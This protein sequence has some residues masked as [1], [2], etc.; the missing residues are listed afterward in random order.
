MEYTVFLIGVRSRHVKAFMAPFSE[1]Y[2][3]KPY[4]YKK[5]EEILAMDRQDP[6]MSD[7]E[8]I[9]SLSVY[10]LMDEHGNMLSTSNPDTKWD[11][12]T[13]LYETSIAKLKRGFANGGDLIPFAVLNSKAEWYD[14]ESEESW[15]ETFYERFIKDRSDETVVSVVRCHL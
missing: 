4:I 3:V 2:K 13:I 15:D 1:G 10:S 6:S 8:Y 7:K 14:R 5:R 11:H 12:Y 9:E